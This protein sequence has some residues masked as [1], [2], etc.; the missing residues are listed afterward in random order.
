MFYYLLFAH[1]LADYP[2]QPNWVASN[3]SRRGVLVLHVLT[4]LLTNIIILWIFISTIGLPVWT[5]L[6]LL[7]VIHFLIDSGKNYLSRIRPNWIKIPYLV[8]QL[9][10]L[11]SI[12]II[13]FLIQNQFG[14]TAFPNNPG[15]VVLA[16]AYLFV[17]YVW[18]ISERVMT[19]DE[20]FYRQSVINDSWSRMLFRAAFLT[21]L[22]GLWLWAGK[23]QFV[24][25]GSLYIPYQARQF[26]R[27]ALITD[28]AVTL[29]V[30]ILIVMIPESQF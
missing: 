29:G 23:S 6:L 9:L 13:S 8:D 24:S 17:T 14:F 27:R 15:W 12:V 18:F 19:Y 26:G 3:K 25:A 22:F 30:F 1:L 16:I 28:L 2:L 10:H 21:G 20:P 7:V 4:H 5:Y 11:I